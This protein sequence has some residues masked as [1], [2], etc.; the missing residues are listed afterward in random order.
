MLNLVTSE[1]QKP[2]TARGESAT[3]RDLTFLLKAARPGFWPTS[4][5]F[6][7]L[8]LSQK[9][10]L[11]QTGRFWLGLFFMG[12]PFGLLIYG[13]NDIMDA[14]LD[15]ENARKDTFLFGARGTRDQLRKLPWAISL[16]HLIFAGIFVWLDGVQMLAWYAALVGATA[17][18]NLPRVGFNRYP[19][20]DMLNQLA[21]LLVFWLSSALNHVPQLPWA[22][23]VFGG[24]FAMHSHLLGEIM[25]VE[26]DRRGGRRTTAVV[27]GV[28]PAKC[29]MMALLTLESWLILHYF[30]D[31][32]IGGFL[33]LGALWFSFDAFVL[34]K[35]RL[36]PLP[37]TR[38]LLTGWN[39][40][41]CAS[42]WWVWSTGA[43]SRP[44]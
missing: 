27:I 23:F 32:I 1:P 25:D 5:W 29:L 28:V 15:R 37:L 41:A 26:L 20:V 34:F 9:G 12:F 8:P 43:F 31:L 7:L 44:Q 13:W 30:H 3:T 6:Y 14:D 11:F 40:V 17:L 22:T 42:A 33:L 2:P 24:L 35:D 38:L 4:I 19:G 18:Y 39:I 16:V 10:Y 36:Y 21:Y